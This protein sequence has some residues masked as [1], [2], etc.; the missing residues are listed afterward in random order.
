MEA[1]AMQLNF[2][3][4]R[5]VADI[6]CYALVLNRRILRVTSDDSKIVDKAS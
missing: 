2:K 5:G 3:F 6:I 1:Q 4:A